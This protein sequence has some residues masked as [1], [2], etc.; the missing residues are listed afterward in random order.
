M[1]I[2][3]AKKELYLSRARQRLLY[4]RTTRPEASRFLEEL[5]EDTYDEIDRSVKRKEYLFDD[6]EGG[7]GGRIPTYNKGMSGFD[8]L[9][10]KKERETAK[11]T[12]IYLL[13]DRV[14]HRTF[15]DGTVIKVTRVANDS[16][17]EIRFDDVGVK[18]V[19]ANYAPIKKIND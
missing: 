12:A 6:Y 2:T 13:G 3:R 5:D 17:L 1:G 16:M 9:K 14:R 8:A 15:G 4:G 7:S 10:S 19:M 18:R 11:T